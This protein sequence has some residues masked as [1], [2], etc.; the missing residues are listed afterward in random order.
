MVE[1]E[2]SSGLVTKPEM[3]LLTEGVKA[4][5]RCLSAGQLGVAPQFGEVNPDSKLEV[6]GIYFHG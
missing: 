2:D 4:D 6:C 1:E 5:T 3:F